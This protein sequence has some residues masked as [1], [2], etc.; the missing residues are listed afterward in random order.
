MATLTGTNGNDVLS[1][2]GYDEVLGLGGDDTITAGENG[3]ALKGGAGNDIITAAGI[4]DDVVAYGQAGDDVIEVDTGGIAYGGT[5]DLT[6]ATDVFHLLEDH[7][8]DHDDFDRV[9][10]Y[11]REQLGEGGEVN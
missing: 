11:A 5:G 9:R 1:G 3:Q 10:D 7:C 4:A 6:K 2:V 8:H